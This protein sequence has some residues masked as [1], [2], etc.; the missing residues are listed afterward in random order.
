MT[1]VQIRTPD[2]WHC[3]L[4]EGEALSVTVDHQARQF[5]RAIVM[6]NLSAPVTTVA[7][8]KTYRDQIIANVPDGLEFTPLM[9]MY[10]T[11]A[12]SVEELVLAKD[13]GWVHAVKLYP[14]GATTRSEFGVLH[15][16]TVEQQL[17]AM[18]ELGLVLAVHGEVVDP[19]VD[20]FDRE[21][22]FLQQQLAPILERFPRLRVVLEHVSTAEAVRFVESAGAL[23]AATITPHHLLLNRNDLLVGGVKPHHY[24]LPVVKRRADQEALIAAALSGDPCFF[25]GT[26]SAPHAKN[27]K[28]SAC[29]C[30]GIYSAYAALEYYAEVFSQHNAMQR[31]SDFSSVYGAEFYGLELNAGCVELE[32]KEWVVPERIAYGDDWIVPLWAGK[33]LQWKRSE[34]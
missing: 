28:E 3:H 19:N 15:W 29:G 33:K 20:I 31:L 1:A 14:R 25:L 11:T 30:A 22:V 32:Q 13:S 7:L 23:C 34:S 12:L 24:C 17:K 9:T 2:D 4:R 8:A 16:H 27:R 10:L 5:R 26:D 21:A 18:E 6:P